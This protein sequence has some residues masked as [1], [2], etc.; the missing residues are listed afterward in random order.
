MKYEDMRTA[1]MFLR[2]GGYAF[3]FDLKSG[4]HHVDICPEHVTYLGFSWEDKGVFRHSICLNSFLSAS[5]LH[6]IYSQKL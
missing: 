3:K 2:K 1:L 5:H 6:R 4:Y